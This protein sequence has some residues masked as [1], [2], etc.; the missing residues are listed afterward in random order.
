MIYK[1]AP[2]AALKLLHGTAFRAPNVY[3]LYYY[4]RDGLQPLAPETI[5]TSEITYE[6]YFAHAIRVS[7]GAFLFNVDD[8]IT[9]ERVSDDNDGMTYRNSDRA[10]SIGVAFELEGDT[11]LV[12]WLASYTYAQ[13]RDPRADVQLSNSPR[14]LAAARATMPL[15][16]ARLFAGVETHYLS[17]R[18]TLDGTTVDAVVLADVTLTA[19]RFARNLDLFVAVTNLFDR[20][21]SDP[22]AEEHPTAAI[23]QDGRTFRVRVAWRF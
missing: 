12:H 8:L 14:H 4:N 17:A 18:E 9:Q 3:E 15:V 6:H 7:A 11:A 10:R 23:P 2:N 20:A 19:R 1:P 5:R 13:A 22:G 16:P 21:Y